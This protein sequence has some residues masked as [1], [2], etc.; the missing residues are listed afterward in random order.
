[1]IP[2]TAARQASLY[3]TNS[4]SLLKLMSIESVMPS[5]HLI[6]C[7][8]H[9]SPALNLSQR[10]SL[11][12]W[13]SCSHQVAKVLSKFQEIVKDRGA[14]QAAVYGVA[15]G[16]KRLINWTTKC[17]LISVCSSILA[18]L[19]CW[20]AELNILLIESTHKDST[21]YPVVS[22]LLRKILTMLSVKLLKLKIPASWVISLS[23]P[24]LFQQK[25]HPQPIQILKLL[26]SL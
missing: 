1:M 12:K 17:F 8:S 22:V 23:S 6:L 3:I 20:T 13:V 19:N 18:L 4:Q 24:H 5:N 15:K 10:Q 7:P 14:W 16:P 9:S 26:S 2:R 25:S 11:C 21:W